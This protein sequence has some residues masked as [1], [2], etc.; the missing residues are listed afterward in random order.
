MAF[1]ETT[2]FPEK[3][4]TYV[5]TNG[6]ITISANM[7]I[8]KLSV[9]GKAGTSTVIGTQSANNGVTTYVSAAQDIDEGE[10]LTYQTTENNAYLDGLTF[11]AAL[12]VILYLT[13]VI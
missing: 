2:N 12:G 11:T 6:S 7:G 1:S 5:L 9:K 8:K 13:G 4:W 3:V 10:V